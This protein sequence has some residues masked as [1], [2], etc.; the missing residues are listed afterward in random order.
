LPFAREGKFKGKGK[1]NGKFKNAGETP[2]LRTAS[3]R[4]NA[5]GIVDFVFI[6]L[7]FLE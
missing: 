6:A 1:F 2:A 4:R 5:A 7:P 3:V